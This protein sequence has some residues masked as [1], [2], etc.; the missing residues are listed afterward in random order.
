MDI[1]SL[2]PL[3]IATCLGACS[4]GPPKPS[5]VALD[6]TATTARSP[7]LYHEE[8]G[9]CAPPLLKDTNTGNTVFIHPGLLML[10]I[11]WGGQRALDTGR[12]MVR[13]GYAG[14]TLEIRTRRGEPIYQRMLEEPGD[15][16]IG[17]HYSMGGAPQTLASALQATAR[18]SRVRE[19]QLVYSPLL[20]EP[21]NF[22][23]L[24]ESVDLDDPHL[25]HVLML[26]SSGNSLLRPNVSAAPA[27]VLKHPKL[28]IIYPE[29]FGLHWDHFS[30]LTDLREADGSDEPRHRRAL[31]LFH[32]IM[33]SLL[34]G[35][36]GQR[37]DSRLARLKLRYARQ[38][39]RPVDPQWYAQ[40]ATAPCPAAT[41]VLQRSGNDTQPAP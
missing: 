13:E 23:H 28:H 1:R 4:S 5:G 7:I 41:A 29:E 18:A 15:R 30:V 24:H 14:T 38:D 17:I 6:N 22:A 2:A 9:R 36:D 11:D 8:P 32:T 19:Q 31:E 34:A 37:I 39:R 26:V 33:D 27:R 20:V 21:Y 40:S 25:G 35:G 12:L 10:G 16:F 3:L